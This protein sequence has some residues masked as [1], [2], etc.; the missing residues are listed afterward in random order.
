MKLLIYT[1]EG[2]KLGLRYKI[3]PILPQFFVMTISYHREQMFFPLQGF[4]NLIQQQMETN[5]GVTMCSQ[6]SQLP[7]H[8]Y[9]G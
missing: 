3:P 4:T 8:T 5:L 7:E 2:D 6:P 9:C 1:K